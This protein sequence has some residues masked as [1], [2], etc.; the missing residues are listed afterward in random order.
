VATTS[1]ER[2]TAAAT[3]RAVRWYLDGGSQTITLTELAGN[4]GVPVTE[5]L[6]MMRLLFDPFLEEKAAPMV[7]PQ[8]YR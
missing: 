5:L 7:V 6:A 2:E 3:Y 1:T 8:R 4:T